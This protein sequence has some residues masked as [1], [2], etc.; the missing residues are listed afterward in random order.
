MPDQPCGKLPFIIGI[1]PYR[2]GR[3]KSID[4]LAIKFFPSLLSFVQN[5]V[6][7][8]VFS[9]LTTCALRRKALEKFGEPIKN[10]RIPKF[11]IATSR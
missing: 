9:A 4:L 7:F 3:Y 8:Y 10:F 1:F 2:L 11:M 6:L 5:A